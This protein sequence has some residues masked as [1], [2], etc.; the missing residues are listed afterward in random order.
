MAHAPYT[1][2]QATSLRTVTTNGIVERCSL[3]VAYHHSD[4]CVSQPTISEDVKKM[5]SNMAIS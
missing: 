5:K 2:E 1:E 3:K 4:Q